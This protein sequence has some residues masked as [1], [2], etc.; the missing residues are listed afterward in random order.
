MKGRIPVYLEVTRKRTFAG[1]VEWPGWCRSGKTPDEALEALVGYADRYARAVAHARLGFQ[2]PASV[3]DLEVVERLEGN[4]TTEFGAPGV[5]PKADER[6]LKPAELKR[7][8]RLLEASWRTFD[9]AW[10]KASRANLEL[11]RGPRGGGRDLLKMEDH[12]MGAEE[13]YLAAL[14]SRPPRGHASGQRM[15]A[16]RETALDALHARAL[17][18]PVADPRQ[19]KRPWSPRFYVRRS[20]WHAL[21]HA[22]EIEDR[23]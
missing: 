1:A 15:A 14:G 5:A 2:R 20:A 21:D 19:T 10:T 17:N 8:S 3:D 6:P 18:K 12:V 23:S 7:Q 13:G 22:W 4:A 9:A 16:I 11:R